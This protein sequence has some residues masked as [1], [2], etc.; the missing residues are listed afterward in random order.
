MEI[1]KLLIPLLSSFGWKLLDNS[2]T[3]KALTRCNDELSGCQAREKALA[4][5]RERTRQREIQ[6]AVWVVIMIAA[7]LLIASRY[8][9]I[10]AR[11]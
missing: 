11:A 8:Y 3:Q 5:A 6:T 4:E 10:A 7:F 2:K 9:T 1:L